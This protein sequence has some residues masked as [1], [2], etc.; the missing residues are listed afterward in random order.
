[1][2][3]FAGYAAAIT[4]RDHVFNDGFL[5]AYHAGQVSHS[6]SQNFGQLPGPRGGVN[7]FLQSPQVIL[8]GNDHDHGIVRLT[9][10]GTIGLQL[11]FPLPTESRSVQWQADL[12]ITP[13]V[14]L[15]GSIAL[16]SADKTDYHLIAWQFDVF[17]GTPFS[18]AAQAF[19]NADTFKNLLEGWLKDTL[20]DIKFPIIDFSYLGP[21]S[22]KAFTSVTVKAVNSA[23]LLGFDMDNGDFSTAGDPNQLGDLAG[24]NDVEVVVNPAAV[25]PLMP[26][27]NRLVQDEIDQYDATLDFL[28]I[29]C[30]EGRFRVKGRA[31]TTGGA[32]NFSLAA[33]P[34]TTFGI[35]GAIIPLTTKKTMVIPARFWAALTFTPADTSVDVEQ[36][37]W[38]TVLEVI[39]S[40]L[41]LGF[42][43]FVDQAFI[44]QTERNI[45]GGIQSSDLNPDGATPMVRRFGDPPT[46]FGI[47]QFE[48]H[49]VGVYIGISSRFEAP[50][51]KLS[52]VKSI[53][54]DFASRNI[55]YDVTLPFDALEGDPFLRVRWTI[56][57]LD[58]GTTLLND[59]AAAGGRLSLQ[60]TPSS[61][62]PGVTRFAV[63]C[64]VYRALGPFMTELLNQT[65]RLTVGPPL[66]N[67][68]FVKWTYQVKNPQFKFDDVANQ[69]RTTGDRTIQRWSKIH[70]VDKPCKNANHRSRFTP[71]VEF[72]DDLPFPV[73][74]IAANRKR[75]CPY[76]FF[77][78]TASTVAAL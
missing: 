35:P 25:Q 63:V 11:N 40:V 66:A 7:F 8:S 52:G 37:D 50:P 4:I 29:T 13:Q 73:A 77:G 64:R 60:F 54:L 3:D 16:L 75:L 26:D 55:R 24:T 39:A 36:S 15:L 44:S 53:P 32:A 22:G 5:S 43:A 58:S 76:C 68:V 28:H 30:E 17:S 19:L 61:I 45:S 12:L 51:A 20:G 59:D 14:L 72:F 47:E 57:N 27:A 2:S 21:F 23:L 48:I 33:V 18:V 69:W 10:W 67:G 74:D 49:S 46:R 71:T 9:G 62:G 6:L 56:V 70:R 65:I 42:A 31:S 41:T 78:G 38:V 34:H 1:M